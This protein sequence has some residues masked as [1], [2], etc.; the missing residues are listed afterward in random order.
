MI[1]QSSSG[2]STIP[3]SAFWT[4]PTNMFYCPLNKTLARMCSNGKLLFAILV[5]ISAATGLC[6]DYCLLWEGYDMESV[7]G[8]RPCTLSLWR[9]ILVIL[10]TAC[11][12]SVV[13][14]SYGFDYSVTSF[15][16]VIIQTS[17]FKEQTKQDS[18]TRSN[19]TGDA[20]K[21]LRAQAPG[22]VD[23]RLLVLDTLAQMLH[24]SSL[25]YLS[26][27]STMGT[28]CRYIWRKWNFP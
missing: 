14:L 6:I 22:M 16:M 10:T 1:P 23:F 2:L 13:F 26:G 12:F 24:S 21:T 27:V 9:F 3:E 19:S 8:Q 5:C 11:V 7:Q 4:L 18:L 15:K 17:K 25:T 20:S 28:G